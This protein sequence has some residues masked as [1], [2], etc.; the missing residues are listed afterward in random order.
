MKI[1]FPNHRSGAL[2]TRKQSTLFIF[3]SI[4]I[5]F[6]AVI[7][8]SYFLKNNFGLLTMAVLG[9]AGILLCLGGAVGTLIL[10][11][12]SKVDGARSAPAKKNVPRITSGWD[13]RPREVIRRFAAVDSASAE[14]SEVL[15]PEPF[16]INNNGWFNDDALECTAHSFMDP[17]PTVEDATAEP[18]L[19][20]HACAVSAYD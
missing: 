13:Y 19:L 14:T 3:S 15:S 4:V 10:F 2:L 1:S 12:W 18:P 16:A 6:F 7:G 8:G 17:D 5:G 11:G 9:I 20:D